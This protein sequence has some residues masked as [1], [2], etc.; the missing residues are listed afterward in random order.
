MVCDRAEILEPIDVVPQRFGAVV[1]SAVPI[2][3]SATEESH[4]FLQRITT[5]LCLYDVERRPYLPAQ[6]HL[7][8][9]IDG[10][11]ETAFPINEPNDPSSGR[12]PFLLVFRTSH[13]V[14]AVHHS[15]LLRAPDTTSSGGSSGFPAYSRLRT[16][17]SPMRGAA[18]SACLRASYLRTVIVTAAVYRRLDSKL[19]SRRS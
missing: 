6:S 12:E 7:V 13:I 4:E 15:T 14:T 11:A 5:R 2:E 18:P 9:A 19:R 17:P 3:L 8:I 1:T 16:A 10:A